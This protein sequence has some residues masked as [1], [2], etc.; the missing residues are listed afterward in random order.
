MGRA[1]SLSCTPPPHPHLAD[2]FEYE[3]PS[4]GQ[5]L[6]LPGSTEAELGPLPGL[7]G[8]GDSMG[9]GSSGGGDAGGTAA[10]G[11]SCS[12]GGGAAAGRTLTLQ[13]WQGVGPW[14]GVGNGA[15]A[16]HL[17][18]SQGKPFTKG[19]RP[20]SLACPPRF[21]AVPQERGVPLEALRA[22]PGAAAARRHAPHRGSDGRPA[23]RA[24]RGGGGGRGGAAGQRVSLHTGWRTGG[25]ARW[26]G[27]PEQVRLSACRVR[28][29]PAP[30]VCL[31]RLLRRARA[32]EFDRPTPL[33]PS[34]PGSQH[35]AGAGGAARQ[36]AAGA[37]RPHR[38]KAANNRAGGRQGALC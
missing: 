1:C 12:G 33:P 38:L 19:G 11:S 26:Q 13:V 31:R 29:R 3:L 17:S 30:L 6:P 7:D 22:A 36:P 14:G 2:L 25:C 20:L 27:L 18:P 35:H 4:L 32:A 9:A 28:C 24:A 16:C 5:P 34:L 21:P 37:G 23:P 10:G 15:V 8:C